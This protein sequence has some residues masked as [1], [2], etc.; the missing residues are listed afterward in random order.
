VSSVLHQVR[1]FLRDEDGPTAVEYA[2][3]LALI[4]VVLRTAV[5]WLGSNAGNTFT[6]VGKKVKSTSS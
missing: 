2:I 3:Q 1:A 6:Y 5:S 4:P